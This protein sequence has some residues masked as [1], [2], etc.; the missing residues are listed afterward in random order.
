MKH[1][2]HNSGFTLVEVLAAAMI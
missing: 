2:R 1:I